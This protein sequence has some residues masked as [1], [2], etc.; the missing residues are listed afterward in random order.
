VKVLFCHQVRKEKLGDRITA[1]QQLV[2]PFGKVS[3][4]IF[5][6]FSNSTLTIA[7]L[8]FVIR[9]KAHPMVM[10]SYLFQ[11]DTASVLHEAI[12]YIKFLHDQATVCYLI[13]FFLPYTSV[14][15]I[16]SHSLIQSRVRSLEFESYDLRNPINVCIHK[17][18]GKP[19]LI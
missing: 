9:L 19:Y 18:M 11:T 1:L 5:L 15:F 4:W 17:L 16:D 7:S 14:S 10:Y 12:E 6:L 13:F 3:F 8:C 2:S